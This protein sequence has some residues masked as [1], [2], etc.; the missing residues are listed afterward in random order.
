MSHSALVVYE[1]IISTVSTATS[2]YY[3]W[4]YLVD[5]YFNPAFLQGAPWPLSAIPLLT[6]L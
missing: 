5:N 3:V 2:I 6:A 4:L 1:F